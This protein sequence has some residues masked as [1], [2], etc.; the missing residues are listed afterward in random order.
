MFYFLTKHSINSLINLSHKPRSVNY[1]V[2]WVKDQSKQTVVI[3]A[4]GTRSVQGCP[5]FPS[6]LILYNP[7]K[8]IR[9]RSRAVKLVKL[10]CSSLIFIIQYLFVYFLFQT[11]DGFIFVVAPDGK[12]MYISE[13]ASVHLGLSQVSSTASHWLYII[14]YMLQRGLTKLFIVSLLYDV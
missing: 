2:W 3:E 11:L 1:V 13:T 14:Y 12:I 9:E 7:Y 4:A 10:I 8:F 6:Q 5:I